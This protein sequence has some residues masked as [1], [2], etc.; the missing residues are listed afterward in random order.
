MPDWPGSRPA[1]SRT[2]RSSYTYFPLIQKP[3]QQTHT[4]K[5]PLNFLSP[6]TEF[7]RTIIPQSR[8]C[9]GLCPPTLLW[10]QCQQSSS[11]QRVCFNCFPSCGLLALNDGGAGRPFIH[12]ILLPS[13]GSLPLSSGAQAP[14]RPLMHPNKLP[15]PSSLLSEPRLKLSPKT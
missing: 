12:V 1:W 8:I 3:F 2:R 10:C 15:Q 7:P 11:C 14:I 13:R 5:L 9:K 6:M 4:T